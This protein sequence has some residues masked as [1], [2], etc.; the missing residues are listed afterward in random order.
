MTP[1]N[2]FSTETA[3]LFILIIFLHLDLVFN[4]A[5]LFWRFAQN[6]LLFEKFSQNYLLLGSLGIEWEIPT[7]ADTQIA[8]EDFTVHS[9]INKFTT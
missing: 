1:G 5:R 4:C 9:G 3:I 2:N 7:V 6:V 8:L